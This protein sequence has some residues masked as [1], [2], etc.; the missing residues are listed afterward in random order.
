MP[1]RTT[2]EAYASIIIAVLIAMLATPWWVQA[3]LLLIL[4]TLV[5]DISFHAPMTAGLERGT[6][7]VIGLVSAGLVALVGLRLVSNQYHVEASGENLL[8]SFFIEMREANSFNVEYSF[9]NRGGGPA[10]ISSL[11]LTAILASNR[12]DEPSANANLCENANPIRMLVTQLSV[13]LGLSEVANTA[14][15][16]QSYRPREISIDGR[17]WPADAPIEVAGGK[18]RTVSATYDI[19]Q[20]DTVKYNVMALCPSVEAYDDVGLG[21]TATCRGLLS[22]R[23]GVGLVAIRAAGRVRILPHPRD[24]LCP[25]A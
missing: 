18:E 6:K 20:A 22:V 15:R 12:A 2:L 17:A 25:P 13:R 19:D 5:I 8:A 14:V 9:V 16:S 24:L 7:A 3:I 23:T 11:G 21:G 1:E 10:S 4:I